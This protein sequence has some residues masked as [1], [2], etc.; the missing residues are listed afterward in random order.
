MKLPGPNGIIT[1]TR[2]YR[3]SLDCARDGAK[4]AES[5]VIAEERCQLDRIVALA[6]EASATQ[7]P[8]ELPADE[9]AFKPSKETKKVKLNPKDPSCSNRFLS[10]SKQ[11]YLHY[12]K[13]CYGMYF[14][15]K[16]LK[17]YFQEH[18]ITVVSTARLGDI[19]WCRDASGRVAKC[20][21]E[22]AGHT[23]LYEPRTTIKSQALSDFLVDW[24]ETQ[25]LPPPP[26]ST[27]WRMHFDGSKMRLGLGAGIVLSSPKGDRLRYVLQNH[28]AAS[29]NSSGKWDA[30]DSNMAS[31]RFLVQ[32]LSGFFAGCKFLHVPRAENEAAD[33]LAKIASS[34]QS[35]P[36][37]VSLEH[38]HK[39]S[40]KPS[41]DSESIHVPDDPA[42]PQ[43]GPATAPTDPAA[44]QPG[45]GTAPTNPA[46]PQLGPVTA[47]AS[48]TTPKPSPRATEPGSGAISP[49]PVVMVVL[50]RV[51]APS[52]ALPIS[53]F[54][55]NGVLPVDET[56]ARQVQRR[57][58]GYSIINNE[59]VKRSSTDVFQRCVKQ[60]KGIEILLDI[61]QGECGH[62]AASRS[63]VAKAFRHGFYW[64]TTL[65]DAESLVLSIITDNGTNFAK[66][67]LAQYYSV[68]GIHL[69]LASV[70]HPQSNGQ[71]KRA[72]GLI[73][74][75]ILL[76][77]ALQGLRHYHSKKIKPLA[78]REGDLVLRLVQVQTGQHK[79]SSP[80]EGPFIVSKALCD[81]NAYY[82]IY[83]RKTNKRNRDTACEE[84]IRPWNA[85]LLHPFYS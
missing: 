14:T 12:Q 85:E 61:H 38:L 53:E 79:L 25:F 82:L 24:T 73:L 27:H 7:I 81:R 78:F 56:E 36:S 2:D 64:P 4:L 71:V 63:L 31:Y 51:T 17:Q 52:W 23:I 22:L 65:E 58:S 41:P 26:D 18:V 84:T 66:G 42:A 55:E 70:A 48:P 11:N 29:N 68:S 50:A 60:G 59:L 37:S 43:P 21:L 80:W 49:E 74:S 57:A 45:P 13:M 8:T 32:K 10:A 39:P 20:A 33:T 47:L 5:L 83:A 72:N 35:I 28:F 62:H 44:P 76:S 6:Q 34:W 46:A 1:V 54:L 67:T 16:K 77:T 69:D 9:A 19:I 40:I 15:A 30:H 3:K 75:G